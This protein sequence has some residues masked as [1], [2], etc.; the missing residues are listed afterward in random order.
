DSAMT[1]LGG[2]GALGFQF[3]DEF[4]AVSLTRVNIDVSAGGA[5][6]NLEANLL[7]MV[8]CRVNAPGGA[9]IL[10]EGNVI[11]DNVGV[12]ASDAVFLDGNGF[13]NADWTITGSQFLADDIAFGVGVSDIDFGLHTVT[14]SVLRGK[15]A[16]AIG[17]NQTLTASNSQL[18]G[19]VK[20]DPDG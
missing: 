5:A 11:L 3:V 17:A 12:Q 7:H 6:M 9:G 15:T 14:N 10:A 1:I 2:N 18:V 8:N 16:A 4:Q 20:V 19:T 13:G